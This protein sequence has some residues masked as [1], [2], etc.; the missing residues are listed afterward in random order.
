M[1]VTQITPVK[2]NVQ[3]QNGIKTTRPVA[4]ASVHESPFYRNPN[5]LKSV[6]QGFLQAFGIKLINQNHLKELS[7]FLTPK[8]IFKLQASA[9][10]QFGEL[11]PEM[12]LIFAKTRKLKGEEFMQTAYDLIGES[13]GY[14][15]KLLPK[16]KILPSYNTSLGNN[17]AITNFL[18]GTISIKKNIESKV[19]IIGSLRHELEHF[20]QYDM[21]LRTEGLGLDKIVGA[22]VSCAIRSTKF[23]GAVTTLGP[24][25]Y[26]HVYNSVNKIFINNLIKE[27]GIIPENSEQGKKA[28]EYLKAFNE[29]IDPD[30][31]N[32]KELDLYYANLTE[33][34]AY[35][36]GRSFSIAYD[37]FMEI[38][39]E[40]A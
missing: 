11:T 29:Y 7:K 27:K 33:Q 32:Q 40:R 5:R 37:R 22:I 4:F 26:G 18:Q 39:R 2:Y 28:K 25:Y 24:N 30:N 1:F 19:H 10:F 6:F 20:M 17:A 23:S 31:S 38:I 15:K 8:Q 35:A 3:N 9:G 13:L 16:L 36:I 21:V 14:S 12:I 34:N